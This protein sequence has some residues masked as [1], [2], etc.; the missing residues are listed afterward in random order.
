M[1][2]EKT[3]RKTRMESLQIKT[4]SDLVVDARL[5]RSNCPVECEGHVV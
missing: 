2:P 4:D 1:R 3:L 5:E